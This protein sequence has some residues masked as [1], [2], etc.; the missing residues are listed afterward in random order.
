MKGS[1]GVYNLHLRTRGGGEKLTLALAE[2][3]SRGRDVFLFHADPLD[4]ASLEQF[5]GVDLSRVKFVR[6]KSAGLLL[7]VLAKVR[8]GRAPA[9][10]L[11]HYLQLRRLKLDVFINNSYASGLACP[12]AR[13]IFMC[14]FPYRPAARPSAGS[15]PRRAKDALV[16]WVE[17]CATGYDVREVADSYSTVAAISRYSAEWVGKMWGRR[18]EV[19]YPPCDHMGP[20]TYKENVVLHVGRF[21]A[22]NGEAERHHKGQGFLLETFKGMKEL[23]AEGWELHF[24]GSVGGDEE[25]AEF[26]AELV[27]SAAGFPVKF[28]F[29]AGLEELRGLYRRASVYWHATGYGFPA[30]AYPARQEHFGI[31]T[32]EAMSAGAVPVVYGSGGQKEIV[33]HGRDGLCWDD[34]AGLVSQTLALARDG[35]LHGRLSQQAVVSSRRFGREAFGASVDRLVERLL[36]GDAEVKGL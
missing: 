14:M 19:I 16:D 29:D 33:T 18:A 4:V 26:A 27:R 17:G 35:E 22:D 6:L 5:F 20:A 2:H 21:V 10:S 12:A 36:S 8:G 11:H 3:L 32:V 34:A 15:L 9:F 31:T 30:E 23:H 1:I 13:G 24:A 25:S 28:H 7:R